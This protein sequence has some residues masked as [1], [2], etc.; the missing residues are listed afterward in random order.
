MVSKLVIFTLKCQNKV[1]GNKPVYFVKTFSYFSCKKNWF[2]FIH[3]SFISYPS[4]F[5]FIYFLSLQTLIHVFPNPAYSYSCISYPC[6]LLFMYFL[7]LHTLIHVF[8]NPANSFLFI[9]FLSLQTL[10][11]LFPIPANSYSFISYPC[12]LLSN[13]IGYA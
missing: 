10:I 2:P 4:I 8:P 13:F 9:Y 11:H 12:K 7:S 3:N 6:K 5:L 1:L